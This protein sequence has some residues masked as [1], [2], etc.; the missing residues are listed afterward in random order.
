MIPIKK[1]NEIVIMEK[2]GKILADVLE[3]VISNVK[4]GVTEI[5]LDRLAEKLTL[6]KGGEP[7]FKKVPGYHHSICV[8]T[9]EVVVHGIPGNYVLKEGDIIG[10]DYGVFLDGFHT[11]MAETVRV[12]KRVKGA[13][14]KIDRF[15]RIGKEAL[16]DGISQVKPGNRIGHISKSIQDK[17]ELE[18]GYSVT[19]SLIGHGVGRQLH[20]EPEVPGYLEGKI[21]NTPLLVPG[22][23]IAVEVIYTMGGPDVVYSGEDDWTIKTSD[24][25]LGGL[26]ERTVLVTKSGNRVITQS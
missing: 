17:V 7:G 24:N 25:S 18:G 13:E 19:R 22:M 14:D 26:F 1:P 23:T 11:D 2:A 10:I 4:P 3:E 15:L 20:E 16:M 5:E 12:G 6:K 21:A 9:N 8:A